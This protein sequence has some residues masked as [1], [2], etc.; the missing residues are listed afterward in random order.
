MI[1]GIPGRRTLLIFR[2]YLFCVAGLLSAVLLPCCLLAQNGESASFEDLAQRADAAREAGNLSAG[3]DLY[4]QALALK[5]DWQ[6]GWWYLGSLLYDNNQFPPA[7]DALRQLT[8]LN[9]QLGGG[10]AMLG[11][12]EYEV[13][14]FDASLGDLQKST[15]MSKD[16][17]P[18]L[19]DV[20]HYHLALLLNAHGE[21][22]AANLQ[23]LPLLRRGRTSEDIQVALGLTMLRVPLL[24]SQVNP[25]TDA[26]VHDA[27]AVAA[28]VDRRQYDQAGEGFRN[29]AAKYP[30][31]SFVHYAWGGM[32]ALQGKDSAAEEQFRIETRITPNSSLAYTEWA[33]LES[34]ATHYKEAALLAT[35]ALQLSADSFMAHYVLGLSLLSTGRASAA[36]PE[37][38]RA[39]DLAPESPEIR[40]SL[41]RAYA[42]VG[43]DTLAR[44]EQA[45]FIRLKRLRE[46]QPSLATPSASRQSETGA[47]PSGQ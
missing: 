9:P 3:I 16:F 7:C 30:H 46:S 11:L 31:T 44:R 22:E 24:P 5:P 43:H 47:P 17:D 8:K 32:L 34:R 41:S 23:L 12:S 37:L 25:S 15:A 45:E 40:Y 18:K 14:Q 21:P 35:K 10:W 4:R 38:E 27:G 33:F 42:Q 13:G 19:A 29:L 28:E 26:L 36:V 2:K 1:T 20:V 39:R 6:E